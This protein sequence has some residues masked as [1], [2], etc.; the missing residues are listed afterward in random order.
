MTKKNK[1]EGGLTSLFKEVRVF[2]VVPILA[3]LKIIRSFEEVTLPALPTRL[4]AHQPVH[5]VVHQPETFLS[6]TDSCV[7][8]LL[9]TGT[10]PP[11]KHSSIH[12][13]DSLKAHSGIH[14]WDSLK[15]IE[16]SKCWSSQSVC[17][18]V[19]SHVLEFPT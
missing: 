1:Q 4:P 19:G 14:S 3:D 9:L 5:S 16:N 10:Q 6:V 8:A 18:R 12:S 7:L 13:W 11:H 15:A 2:E 17:A